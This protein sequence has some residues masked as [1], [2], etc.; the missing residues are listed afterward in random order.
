MRV[1]GGTDAWQSVDRSRGYE[2]RRLSVSTRAT[3]R[4]GAAIEQHFVG[5]SVGRGIV[6]EVGVKFDWG[7]R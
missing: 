2:S 7:N 3:H 6:A 1:D 4:A 5:A